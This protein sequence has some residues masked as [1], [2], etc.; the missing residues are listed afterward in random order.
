MDAVLAGVLG[1]PLHFSVEIGNREGFGELH[2]A[3]AL[4]PGR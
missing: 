4:D 1:V 3:V 2:A